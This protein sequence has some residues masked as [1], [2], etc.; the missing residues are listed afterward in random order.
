VTNQIIFQHEV[1]IN[2]PLAHV[3]RFVA[4]EE[5]L[6]QWWGNA[7]A[8]EAKEGGRC[9]EWRRQGERLAHWLGVVTLYAPPSQLTMTLRGQDIPA[10][11]PQLAT[12][13]ITLEAHGEETRVHV[14]HRA[15]DMATMPQPDLPGR[16]PT[17]IPLPHAPQGVPRAQLD[18]PAP[19]SL[20]MPAPQPTV[21][22]IEP[23]RWL[24]GQTAAGVIQA[25]WEARITSL[26]ACASFP[27][28]T[29]S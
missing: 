4:T 12:I 25:R 15:F 23:N 3:W 16:A 1:V 27:D 5:G 21:G 7:I 6:R 13:H 29:G 14:T 20:P 24:V 11:E 17:G 10:D 28:S 18:H 8:L 2:A 22:N 9:E 26:I 19:G